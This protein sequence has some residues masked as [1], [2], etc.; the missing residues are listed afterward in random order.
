MSQVNVPRRFGDALLVDDL[1]VQIADVP[2]LMEVAIAATDA[3]DAYLLSAGVSQAIRDVLEDDPGAVL[4]A[5]RTA[6]AGTSGALARTV[7]RGARALSRSIVAARDATGTRQPL[8][9]AAD[10][11]DQHVTELARTLLAGEWQPDAAKLLVEILESPAVSG[12]AARE[13]TLSL[14]SCFRSFDLRPVD[15]ERLASLVAGRLRGSAPRALVLGVRSSGSYLAPLLAVALESLGIGSA[16]WRTTRPGRTP[17]RA[18]RELIS[19]AANLGWS[20]VLVDDPPDTGG[21]LGGAAR[22]VVALGF[23]KDAICLAY[24]VHEDGAVPAPLGSFSTAVLDWRDW[25]VLRL[26]DAPH[27]AQLLSSRVDALGTVTSLTPLQLPERPFPNGHARAGYRATFETPTGALVREVVAEGTGL[28]YLGRHPL[29]IADALE[30]RVPDVL[31]YGDGVLVRRWLDESSRAA[32]DTPERVRAAVDYVAVRHAALPARR[33]AA[34][35]MAGRQPAWEVAS[36]LLAAPYREA[37]LAV[38]TVA[39]DAAV[40]AL[41]APS[42]PSVI[43]GATGPGSW[44]HDGDRAGEGGLRRARV[45]APRRRVLRRRLRPRRAHRGLGEPVP[46]R[47]RPRAL[48]AAH[49]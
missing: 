2:E 41:L 34:A 39:L 36:R 3:L 15:V 47:G 6:A 14:P 23:P 30:G 21:A 1:H 32:L 20:L 11:I 26:L 46:R 33:D 25:D 17:T 13:A 35:S 10:R 12:S 45:L 28:G 22:D 18:T 4:R 37:G 24:A 48:R 44:F 5:G 7:T 9:V 49:R 16:T 43:D 19:S 8:A 42:R 40:R 31:A 38:R 29:A 27:V